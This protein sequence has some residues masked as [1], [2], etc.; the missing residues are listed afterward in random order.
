M[1]HISLAAVSV[2][3]GVFVFLNRSRMCSTTGKIA[4]VSVPCGVFVF[5]NSTGISNTG[6]A[7]LFPSPAGSSY[8]SI[9]S[10]C[11]HPRRSQRV[12]VPCGVFVFLNAREDADNWI[13]RRF[14]PLRG[15]RISQ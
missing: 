2:P 11:A 8:F 5:L 10:I 9:P 7:D 1:I 6:T 4:S 13:L 12:S 3:C 14:R 15:L